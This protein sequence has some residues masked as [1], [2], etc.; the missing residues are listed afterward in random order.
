MPHQLSQYAFEL[1]DIDEWL[2]GDDRT[3]Q[4]VVTDG[5]GDPVDI[6]GGTVSWGLWDRAY[7]DDPADA[8]LTGDD[9]GVEIVTD[10]R[11]D[12]TAGEFEVRIDGGA[13]A[14]LYGD[15]HHRPAVEQTDGS[16]ASWRGEATI[17]A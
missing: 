11:V 15:Y 4:F 8:V 14:D 7:Q 12:T 16:R 17:T 13:T 10:S 5:D 3:L 2:S 6:S 9:S 1:P